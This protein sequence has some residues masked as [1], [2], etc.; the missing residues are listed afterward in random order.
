MFTAFLMRWYRS[1]GISGDN[2]L[3]F[4][5]R[6]ILLPVTHFTCATPWL[7]LSITPT[8]YFH[9]SVSQH[10]IICV[11]QNKVKHTDLRRS[12]SLLGQL[13]YLLFHI[14]RRHFQPLQ[15]NTVMLRCV[16]IFH[17]IANKELWC[18][19]EV[20]CTVPMERIACRAMLTGKFPFCKTE[21][22]VNNWQWECKRCRIE[23]IEYTLDCA[24]DPWLWVSIQ[25]DRI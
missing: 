7:S 9:C 18:K 24:C 11:K 3:A 1:S 16:S 12:Q 25:W 20:C 17:N 19:A 21:T 4:S 22:L 13:V 6:R 15:T 23:N 8:K 5:I 14:F 2:P 10:S